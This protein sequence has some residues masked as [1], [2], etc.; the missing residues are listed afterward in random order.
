MGD[1]GFQALEA[2]NAREALDAIESSGRAIDLVFTD[3]RMPGEMD[4]IGLAQWVHSNL[5]AI[6][7]IVASGH[8]GNADL[9]EAAGEDFCAKPYQ[10]DQVV[11]K[12]RA[13]LAM[14]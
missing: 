12:I 10:L 5:P 13:R 6:P 14:Q 3:I 1:N 11:A 4:G 2:A 8:V 7:V 9:A